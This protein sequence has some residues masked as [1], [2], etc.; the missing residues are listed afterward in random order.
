MTG[1]KDNWVKEGEIM[2]WKLQ[3]VVVPVSDVDA[4]RAFY[5]E[6]LGFKVDTD[7][8]AGE[9]F[10]IVQLTPPGSAC[11][12]SIGKGVAKAKPGS[13]QGMHLVVT[14]LDAARAELI[15]RGVEVGEPFHFDEGGVRQGADPKRRDYAS[16]LS[17]EDPDGNGWLVQEVK[18][19]AK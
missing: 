8:R 6:K 13:A 9:D 4:A 17:F 14:D 10:R 19:S 1:S 18:G 16:F 15:E 2:D 5:V 3:V 7:Y 12:I 11:S